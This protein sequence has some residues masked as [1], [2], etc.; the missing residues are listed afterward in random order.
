MGIQIS[1][2]IEHWGFTQHRAHTF[3]F[4]FPCLLKTVIKLWRRKK[5]ASP[6]FFVASIL[7][8]HLSTHLH[9][10]IFDQFSVQPEWSAIIGIFHNGQRLVHIYNFYENDD[11]WRN[12]Y[13]RRSVT[14]GCTPPID[15][16]Y[17]LP[18]ITYF[19]AIRK[20]SKRFTF[21]RDPY[22]TLYLFL[23]DITYLLPSF[24]GGMLNCSHKKIFLPKIQMTWFNPA[25]PWKAS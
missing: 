21:D 12:I 16:W 6:P 17:I 14:T 19:I 9:S 25:D 7:F 22:S 5:D 20:K 8:Y 1:I 24:W 18:Q 4:A 13:W 15:Y 11:E 3:L 10:N 23:N 2:S